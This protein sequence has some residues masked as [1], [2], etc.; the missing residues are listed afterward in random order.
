MFINMWRGFKNEK[1][2]KKCDFFLRET[3]LS[4]AKLALAETFAPKVSSMFSN[5]LNEM[6]EELNENNEEEKTL[7]EILDSLEGNDELPNEEEPLEDEIPMDDESED[8]F[9]EGENLEQE[10]VVDLTVEELKDVIR[11]VMQELNGEDETEMDLE[12]TT[13][14]E[15]ETPMDDDEDINLD[16]ILDEM[17]TNTENEFSG[18]ASGLD[19]VVDTLKSLVAKTPDALNKISEFLSDLAAGAGSA[20]RSEELQEVEDKLKQKTQQLD[21]LNLLNAKLI[22]VN[23]VFRTKNLTESQKVKVINAFDRATSLKEVKNTSE[24]IKEAF[25]GNTITGKPLRENIGRA[26]NPAGVAQQ[27]PQI[28]N[29]DTAFINRMQQ[30]AGIKI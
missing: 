28:L 2:N 17:G 24:T 30:L 12:D 29:E 14:D 27:K 7:D 5:R 6:E 3:A 20:L 10:D 4:N 9:P 13:D 1:K 15:S 16:E 19:S 21:E 8:E 18:A 11:S 23:K 26:S 25:T 22:G